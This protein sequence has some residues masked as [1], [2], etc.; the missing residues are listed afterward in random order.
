MRQQKIKL[1]A[2]HKVVKEAI[3]EQ[4]NETDKGVNRGNSWKKTIS[5]KGTVRVQRP[6]GRNELRVS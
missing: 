6:R 1:L 3:F 4:K 2:L 5:S